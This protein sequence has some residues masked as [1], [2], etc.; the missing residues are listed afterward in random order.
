MLVVADLSPYAAWLQ[1]ILRVL[2]TA[3]VVAIGLGAS[4]LGFP[5]RHPEKRM[6]PR[7]GGTS[8]ARG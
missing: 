3:S 4:W 5:S 2:D 8:L 6:P 1:P 7:P